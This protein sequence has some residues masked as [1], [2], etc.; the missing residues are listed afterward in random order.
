MTTSKIVE[1]STRTSL[2]SQAVIRGHSENNFRD[3]LQN[4]FG[5][6]VEEDGAET[7]IGSDTED[8]AGLDAAAAAAS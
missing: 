5:L 3:F 6:V 1:M 4:A 8:P 2:W 7:S